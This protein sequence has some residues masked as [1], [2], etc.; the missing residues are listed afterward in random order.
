M[1][2]V[3]FRNRETKMY[4]TRLFNED[5]TDRGQDECLTYNGAVGFA[6]SRAGMI[7]ST[8]VTRGEITEEEAM[9]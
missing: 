8:P 2:A 6:E 3:I 4:L 5:G 1:F 7:A 9:E